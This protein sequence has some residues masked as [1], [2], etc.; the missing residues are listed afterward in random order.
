[1]ASDAAVPAVLVGATLGVNTAVVVT[2]FQI[3]VSEYL[4][5]RDAL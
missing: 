2:A 1:M 5:H 3:M 4:T